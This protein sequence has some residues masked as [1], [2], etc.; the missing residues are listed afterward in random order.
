[1][2]A[3]VSHEPTTVAAAVVV[4]LLIQSIWEFLRQ[5]H[6]EAQ[7]GAMTN[8]YKSGARLMA[9]NAPRPRYYFWYLKGH[10]DL[11]MTKVLLYPAY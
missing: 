8:L 1:M 11:G 3:A 2:V 10:S 7:A 9:C 6:Q 5:G 4:L